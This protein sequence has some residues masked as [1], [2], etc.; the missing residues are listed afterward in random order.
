[1][2]SVVRIF[3]VV[4]A[5]SLVALSQTVG[6]GLRGIVND[7]SGAAIP[8]AGI[9]IHNIETGVS[10]TLK[11]DAGGR[12]GEP[13]VQPGEYELHVSAQGF[14]PLVRKGVHLAV[15]QDAVVDVELQ[16]SAAGTEITVTGAAER[17]NT[18]S[19]ALSGLVDEK[20]MRDLPLNG[21]SFQ[22]LA[23]LETG[24]N[25]VNAAGNDPVGGRTPKISMNGARPELSSFLLDG[26]DIND[27]YNKT[28]GSVGGV[29][30]GVEAVLEFQ[31]LTNS[32]SAEF[33]RA[34]G[35]VINAVTR[36]GTNQIHG[37][38][39]EFL[40]NSA[41][42][43]KNYFDPATQPIPPFKRNQFGATA[44]GP[45]RK[46][47]TFFFGSFESLI[48]RL[49]VTGVTSVPD[50]NARTGVL[51]SGNITVNPA[52]KPIIDTLFPVPNGR[53]LGGGVA[54]YLFTAAQPT[55][56]EFG[57]GRID[58]RFSTANS[59]FGRYTIDN[60]TVDRP[61]TTKAP[62]TN[63]KERSRNQYITLSDQHVFSPTVMNTI[64]FGLNRSDHES[65]NERTISIPPQLSWIPGQ[66][67]GYMT[68]SGVVTEDFGDYR[69]PR[70][71]RLNNWQYGDT[72]F[73]SRGIHSLRAGADFQRIQF[74]QHTTNQV[75]GL[76]TFTS[77]ANFLQGIPSQFDFAVPGGVDPDRG[78]RQ[79]LF[80]FF[81]QD[82]IRLRRNLTVNLGVR[83]EFVTVPTEVNG[84][85]SNLRRVT[86]P[87]ITVGNPW[88]AN[89]SLKNFSPRI[90]IA[91]DPFSDGK[92]SVRA[93]FGMFDDEI[94]PKYYV[95][96]GSTNPPFTQRSSIVRPTFP[97]LLAGFDPNHVLYQMQTLNYDLQNPYALQFNAGVQ[98]SL[99]GDWMVSAAY[100]GSRGVHLFRVGDANLAP[101]TDVNGVKVYHPELGRRNPNFASAAQRISD[102]Q[103]FYN[104]LQLSAQKRL[105]G[106]LRAQ[107]SYTFSRAIDDS[108]GVNSQDYSDGTPY[109]LDFYD[110]KADRGLSSYWAKHV[111]AGNWSYELPFAKSM[112]GAAGFLLKGWQIN[113]ITTVQSGHPFEVREGFNRSGNL[114]TVNYAM[115]ERPDLKPGWS[116]NPILG[117]P[118]RYWD[119]NAFML[120]PANQR[121]NLGRNTLIGPGLVDFDFSLAKLFPITETR[122]IEFR[123]ESFN[124]PNHPNFAVPSGLIAFTGVDANG[125]P[126]IAPNWGVI[127]STVTTSRQIQFG[128]KLVF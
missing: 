71:D 34:A 24:V 78:F 40:R 74:N 27:V 45:I 31:V 119:I 16:I 54:Q 82:D 107:I 114:N 32:Y 3:G 86:D 33:G 42:D 79:S 118:S 108:S 103:S 106:G 128:L 63:T 8:N 6:A 65:V 50:V 44:G 83:Y 4:F 12:W 39:F 127:S 30:L 93:G 94:L 60:G 121:G 9:E 2:T 122:R 29:L 109:V 100:S 56:E 62:G 75:G 57:Q 28:P 23:L 5:A 55:N 70:L 85:I 7:P 67:F 115:H 110:R 26:T 37:S 61:P 104:A 124:L 36:S 35:G 47:R 113:S 116:N 41:L 69:L 91:W 66:P 10:R 1:M 95:F 87:G 89:P 105:P 96:S 125:N 58:H 76:L 17:V 21:R 25:A 80:A 102:S 53:N 84:K 92:T 120:Q 90:G 101:S 88:F 18:T 117:G 46:D 81:A 112:N 48:D 22:Q 98:R 49:G 11:A 72:V 99:P 64:R 14:Q 73:V 111:F 38:A 97:N 43:S 68:I 51:P 77:L 59:F 123:A 19:G 15:G 52:I 126:V 20:Q 13:V